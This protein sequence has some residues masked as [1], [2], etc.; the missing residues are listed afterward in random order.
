M[1]VF[2]QQFLPLFQRGVLVLPLQDDDFASGSGRKTVENIANTVHHLCLDLRMFDAWKKL[3]NIC[4]LA[5]WN[6]IS[7]T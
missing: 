7:P 2:H 1:N 4:Y 5:K 3:N 6:N